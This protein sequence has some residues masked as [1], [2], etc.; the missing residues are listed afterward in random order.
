MEK[1]QIL[2]Q[3][4]QEEA[5]FVRQVAAKNKI[6]SGLRVDA[7]ILQAELKKRDEIIEEYETSFG[8][9]LKQ[10]V[11]L[12]GKRIR[13]SGARLRNFVARGKKEDDSTYQ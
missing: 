7:T 5:A 3:Q 12:S 11:K 10:S 1:R 8:K 4:K 2:D 6:I 9:I 13:R